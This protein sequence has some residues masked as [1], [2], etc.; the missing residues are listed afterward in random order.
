[1]MQLCD[2]LTRRSFDR[3]GKFLVAITLICSLTV[4][5]NTLRN[6]YAE[7]SRQERYR[8]YLHEVI[9]LFT[10]IKVLKNISKLCIPF[11]LG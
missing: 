11:P 3:P 9:I 8:T 5:V 7:S 6:R 4:F 10:I 1:M 2:H